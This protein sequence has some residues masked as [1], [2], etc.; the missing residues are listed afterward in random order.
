LKADSAFNKAVRIQPDFAE[1]WCNR[2]ITLSRLKRY[3]EAI[4]SYNRAVEIQPDYY[5]ASAKSG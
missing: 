4:D 3:Q 2:G 5:Q 1:A